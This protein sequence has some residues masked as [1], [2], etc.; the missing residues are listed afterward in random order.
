VKLTAAD[1]L[2]IAAATGFQDEL[3]EKVLHLIGLLG[4]LNAHPFL[5]GRWALKGGTALN[6]FVLDA[7]RL[8][9]DIDLN[10]TGAVDLGTM[11]LERPQIEE[12]AR[13]VFAREEFGVT[14][15]PREHAGGKWRLSYPG[16]RGQGGTVEVDLNWMFRLPLW[17]VRPHDSHQFGTFQARGI[18]ILDIHELAAGKL[19][20]LL[21][22][23]QARDLFDSHRLLGS[24]LIERERLRL[25]FVVYG[26]MNRKDWRSVTVDDVDSD[27]DELGERLLPTLNVRERGDHIS[28]AEYGRRLVEECREALSAVLPL[29]ENERAFLDLLLDRGEIA[30]SLLTSDASLQDRIRRQPLLEWK[31][32]NVRQYMA[33]P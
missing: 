31:A 17:E 10:Y 6:L 26:A 27:T 33:G 2:P 8:S 7:P 22:R 18:P 28:S 30:P 21:S 3:M 4:A 16:F 23:K 24:G 9:L 32:L 25:A 5:K 20:A 15:T 12:A 29:A 1:I 14:R 13:S 11:Q 19:A